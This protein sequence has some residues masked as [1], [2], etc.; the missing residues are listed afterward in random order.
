MK[1]ALSEV[2]NDFDP[3]N[4]MEYYPR[5]GGGTSTVKW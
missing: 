5:G 2:W 4:D 3:Y 1:K